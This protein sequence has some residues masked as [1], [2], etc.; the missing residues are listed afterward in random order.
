MCT[1][2]M[3]IEMPGSIEVEFENLRLRQQ[4]KSRKQKINVFFFYNKKKINKK[5]T[6]N[7]TVKNETV[8]KS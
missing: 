7:K 2:K 6:D 4:L 5:T 8:I 3:A 1:L